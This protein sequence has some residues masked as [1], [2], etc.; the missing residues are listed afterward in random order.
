MRLNAERWEDRGDYRVSVLH[1]F[2]GGTFVQL[3][4]IKGKVSRH[5]HKKQTEV[6][7][8]VDGNGTLEIGDEKHHAKCGDVF[9]CSPETVH[10]V[11]G[12]LKILVFKYN[13]EKED[14]YWLDS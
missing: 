11:E 8:V 2:D 9:L 4:E 13:Y 12:N 1:K 7:V 3:V 6:F 10:S 5:L 14:N